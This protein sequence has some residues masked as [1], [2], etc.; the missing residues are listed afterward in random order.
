LE[1]EVRTQQGEIVL[2][3]QAEPF[4]QQSGMR[5]V[6]AGELVMRSFVYGPSEAG[7]AAQHFQQLPGGQYRY[8]LRLHAPQ[9]ESDDEYCDAISVDESLFLDLVQPWN[10]DTIDELRPPLTWTISGS[11]PSVQTADVRIT[12]SP[13]PGGESAAQALAS[14]RPLFMVPHVKQRTLP[15]PVG[16][17]DLE[18]G[19]CYA[20]QAELLDGSRVVDRSEPWS[21]CVRL[22]PQPDEEK[23][24]LLR[25]DGKRSVYQV[26]NDRLFFRTDERYA[27]SDLHCRI[28]NARQEP[29]LPVVK[30]DQTSSS[31][32]APNAAPKNVGANLYELDLGPYGLDDGSYDLIVSDEKAH[33][34]RLAFQIN[35]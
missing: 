32:D 17:A 2:S 6:S 12:L 24:V 3:F 34:F 30:R 22:Q 33:V 15:Y 9:A 10:G 5:T 4:H 20:W 25:T 31:P 26:T 27:N 18:R 13:M 23:Y 28:L 21:F 14:E 16:I 1:G 11:A 19:K 29:L 35:H 8:C 7:R